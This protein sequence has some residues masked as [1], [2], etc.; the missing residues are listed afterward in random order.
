VLGG[1]TE[2]GAHNW[3]CG[4]EGETGS[5]RAGEDGMEAQRVNREG[6]SVGWRAEAATRGLD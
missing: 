2:A 3:S 4:G 5:G 1:W 6:K